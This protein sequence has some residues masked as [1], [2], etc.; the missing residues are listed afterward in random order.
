MFYKTGVDI[1]NPKSMWE[2]LHNHFTYST[3]NSWNSGR[4]IAHNVK[5]YNLKLEGDWT[6]AARFLF[7]DQDLGDLQFLIQEKIDDFVAEHPMYRVHFNGR[8]GGYLVLYN[9]DNNSNIL[10][11]WIWGYQ[12]YEDFKEDIHNDYG[13]TVK[14]FIEELRVWTELVRD[15]DRLCDDL[16]DLVNEYS[17]MDYDNFILAEVIDRFNGRY[18]EDLEYLE[19]APLTIGKEGV[20]ISSIQQLDCLVEAL[21]RL[22]GENRDRVEINNFILKLKED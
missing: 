21:L 2:F 4:S 14:E 1:S 22:F 18:C 3:C 7:D 11:D 6:V 15:F 19:F 5:L 17:K 8:Q 12:T 9:R 13:Q 10:P 20:D 16:R